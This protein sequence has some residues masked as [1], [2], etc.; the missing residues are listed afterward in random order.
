MRQRMRFFTAVV[1]GPQY[2][3]SYYAN[4]ENKK[5]IHKKQVSIKEESHYQNRKKLIGNYYYPGNQSR[6]LCRKF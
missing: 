2:N 1:T 5:Y 6:C 4:N 3:I